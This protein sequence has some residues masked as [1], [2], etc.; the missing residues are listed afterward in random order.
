KRQSLRERQDRR[1]VDRA[2]SARY[3]GRTS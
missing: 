2:M 1:E 3:K